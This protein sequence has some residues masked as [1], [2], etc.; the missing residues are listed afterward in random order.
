METNSRVGWGFKAPLGLLGLCMAFC[1]PSAQA[2]IL[3]LQGSGLGGSVPLTMN[4][5]VETVFAGQLFGNLDG[6]S[7]ITYCLDLFTGIDYIA[8]NT[9]TGP[10]SGYSNGGRASWILENYGGRVNGNESAMALQLALWD[11]VHDGGDGLSVGSVILDGSA[12]ATIRNAAQ[13]IILAS[14]GHSSSNATI[15]Y[16]VDPS[17]GF[18]A[19]TL[20]TFDPSL[21][22][23]EPSTYG[24]M[25][26]GLTVILARWKRKRLTA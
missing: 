7:I 6:R 23:P 12:S 13:D 17:T 16:N 14:F 2:G 1:V 8:Y 9:T 22:T 10:P 25:G 5:T 26:V 19:Q 3:T 20:I 4:A 18:D 24:L 15:L 21:A 11:V